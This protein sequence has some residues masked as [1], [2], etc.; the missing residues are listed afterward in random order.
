[1]VRISHLIDVCLGDHPLGCD[2]LTD[3]TECMQLYL[4]VWE[5]MSSRR[6]LSFED[7]CHFVYVSDLFMDMDRY[8]A[9]M[10]GRDGMTNYSHMLRD[11]H[12]AIAFET[13]GNL[14]RYSQQ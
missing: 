4:D 7:V 12:I 6:E 8:T 2:Y 13:Y 14:Y 1:M 5:A 11:G 9:L 3:W 10:T